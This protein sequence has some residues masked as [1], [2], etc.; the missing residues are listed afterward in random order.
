MSIELEPADI[1]HLRAER[2]D[3]ARDVIGVDPFDFLQRVQ[4]RHGR[5]SGKGRVVAILDNILSGLRNDAS[6]TLRYRIAIVP[7]SHSGL[8]HG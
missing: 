5:R 8:G 6:M 2:D 4:D 1:G 3:R 7:S